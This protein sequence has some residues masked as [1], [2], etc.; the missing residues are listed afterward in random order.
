MAEG[1][2]GQDHRRRGGQ[3]T[4]SEFKKIIYMGIEISKKYSMSRIGESDDMSG[5]KSSGNV[6][7]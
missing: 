5:A 4:G 2:K 7:K 3:V 6:E 1:A